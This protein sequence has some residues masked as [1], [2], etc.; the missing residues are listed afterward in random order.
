MFYIPGVCKEFIEQDK[1]LKALAD[2]LK[3][4][5]AAITGYYKGQRGTEQAG[6]CFWLQELAAVVWW[7]RK[8][9]HGG[10]RR[11]G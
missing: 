9:F 5:T 6:Y 3:N 7:G 8:G 1:M 11:E 4:D 10:I 2:L